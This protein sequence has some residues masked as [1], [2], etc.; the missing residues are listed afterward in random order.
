M[1]KSIFIFRRDF[2]IFDNIGL[3]ECIKKSSVIYPIFIFTP[4]QI[5]NVN[6]YK[7]NNSVQFMIE[8]LYDLNENISLNF[9]Y[10]K[11]LLVIKD[12]IKKNNITDIFTNTD[13]TPFSVK[14]DLDL[15][16]L[17]DQ[18]KIN[19]HLFHD[20]CL[21]EPKTILTGSGGVYQKFTPFYN[22]V[23]TRPVEKP[24]TLKF[25]NYKKVKSKYLI[26][27]NKIES[28]YVKNP[29]IY[30]N[31]GRK[32]GMKIVKNLKDYKDYDKRRDYFNYETT[33][34]SSYLKYGCVSI[35]EV[36]HKIKNEHNKNH[37]LIRQLIWRDFYYHLGYEFS[38]VFKGPLKKKYKDIEWSDDKKLFK[39]WTEGKTGYPIID[40]SMRCLNETGKLHNR[41]RLLVA[42]FLIKNL[43]INW[44]WG[45]KYFATK[46]IDYDPLVNN[47][48]WQWVSSTGADSQPYF[49]IFNPMTQQ[50]KYDSKGDFILKWIPELKNIPLKDIHKWTEIYEKYPNIYLKP[51]VDYKKSKEE[52]IKKYKKVI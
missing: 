27:K 9:L 24:M 20:I 47:G 14:R 46:L 34:L 18:I 38:Y 45:E 51:I 41:G 10:G 16:K 44:M 6:K 21:F 3:N 30:L 15:K 1:S 5:T 17:C 49:R 7:S 13:Y 29:N 35:R 52:I 42:S 32:N 22:N 37:S 19:L 23:I 28:F 2:R 43:H 40:S 39:K 50:K 36:F 31:G 26:D 4:K 8:S 12:I 25:N 48:N 33:N 11:N